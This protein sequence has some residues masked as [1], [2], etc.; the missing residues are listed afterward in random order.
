VMVASNTTAPSIPV[1]EIIQKFAAKEAEFARARDNYTYHQTV[2]IQELDDDGVARG[3]Y[4][5]VSDII[6]TPEGK[7][8]ERVV[9]A[10]VSTLRNILLTPEDEQDLRNVQPFVLTTKDIPKYNINYLGTQKVDELDT[11]VFAVKPKTMEPGQRYFEGQIWVDQRDLQIVKTYGQG[12][13]ERRD[14]KRKGKGENL[15][16]KFTTWREQIDNQYWFPTYTRADDTLHFVASDIHIRE[17]VKY[18]DYKRFGS[19]VKILYEGKEVPKA[20]RKDQKQTPDQK[21]PEEK[22]PNPPQK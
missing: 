3:R 15:Y 5:I 16:P 17:I 11:Y 10:P 9:R 4:E 22:D 14:T 1:E 8:I 6:F 2:R 7:R 12:V 21:K 13:P 19:S 18:E 20:D